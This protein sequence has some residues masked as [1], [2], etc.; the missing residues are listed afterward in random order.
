MAGLRHDRFIDDGAR[1]NMRA[2]RNSAVRKQGA[3]RDV[4]APFAVPQFATHGDAVGRM[5]QRSR[6]TIHSFIG[7]SYAH[8]AVPGQHGPVPS[9]DDVVA[10][11][12]LIAA[13]VL[14][15]AWAMIDARRAQGMALESIFSHLLVPAARLLAE[16]WEED[17][18]PYQEMAVGMLHL[19]Q[20]LHGLSPAYSIEGECQSRNRRVLL[21]SAPAERDMLGVYMVT[22]FHRC[23]ASEFFHHAGWEVWRSL[24]TSRTQLMGILRSQW[25]DVIDVSASC[26]A[27]LP[28]LSADL[29]EM[30]KASRNSR[31]GVMVGGPAFCDHPEFVAS[32]GADGFVSDL[33]DTMVEAEVLMALRER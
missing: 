31:V 26:E 25:F 27:R 16:R 33:R 28:L 23:V 7:Q 24:P 18:C 1:R 21:V 6:A 19:Q 14:D 20:L 30:R 17:M 10:F 13:P 29:A 32:V 8:A 15:A 11:T 3:R 2:S 22:E 12:S 5:Q 4:D 9:G